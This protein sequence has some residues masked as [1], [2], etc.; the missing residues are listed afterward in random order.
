MKRILVV[1]PWLPWPLNSG[2]NQAIVNGLA[3]IADKFQVFVLYID[4]QRNC[5][6]QELSEM[7]KH[8]PQITFIPYF[9]FGSIVGAVKNILFG[10]F[11]S[12]RFK[13]L[14]NYKRPSKKISNFIRKV[15]N[16]NKIDMVQCEMVDTLPL[17]EDLPLNV[18]KIFVHHEIRYVLCEQLLKNKR[19]VARYRSILEKGKIREIALLNK[20]DTVITLSESD[21]EKLRGAGVNTVVKPSLAVV[22]MEKREMPKIGSLKRMVFIGSDSHMPN[23]NG[24]NWFLENCLKK[25]ESRYF[26]IEM[27][28]VGLWNSKNQQRIKKKFPGVHFCGF[29]Q[30]L[31]DCIRDSVM[32]VPIIQGS[33]IRMK[34][35]EAANHMVPVVST[36]IGADGLPLENGK[37][38]LIA[39]DPDEFVASICNLKEN[40]LLQ[41]H[42]IKNMRYLV[43]QHYSLEVLKKNRISIL[44]SVMELDD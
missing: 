38:C 17:V 5:H 4:Y 19:G 20:F 23:Y 13:Y 39:D 12:Y 18:K 24:M 3:A 9:N 11:F 29:V 2:G 37:H 40:V 32:I 35:L 10:R 33:G 14:V 25:I 36:S 28:V 42:L 41:E 15:I 16:E 21:A 34:I 31:Q 1:L 6:R 22:A 26:D 27:Y 44:S 7:K 8:F 30:N 43:E